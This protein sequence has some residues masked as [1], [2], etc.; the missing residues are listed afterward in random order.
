MKDTQGFAGPAGT[1]SP[2]GLPGDMPDFTPVRL[3]GRSDGWTPERAASNNITN[4]AY[5]PRHQ[6]GAFLLYMR[7]KFCFIKVT[8]KMR[9][10]RRSRMQVLTR[11]LMARRQAR[12]TADM[13]NRFR[14][15]GDE[16]RQR[17]AD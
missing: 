6:N 16:A 12:E 15:K 1:I 7:P 11:F 5:Q 13:S 17:A 2:A 3:R 9:A 14:G 8:Q 4:G 10:P